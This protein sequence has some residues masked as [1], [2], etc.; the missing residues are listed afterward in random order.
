MQF[1]EHKCILRFN[2]FQLRS[3]VMFAHALEK[4]HL[5]Y[6][7]P[8]FDDFDT[9][10][11][12]QRN[13]QN[14]QDQNLLWQKA[15]NLRVQIKYT[16]TTRSYLPDPKVPTKIHV[17]CA[18]EL[19]VHILCNYGTR[20]NSTCLCAILVSIKHGQLHPHIFVQLWYTR[21][22]RARVVSLIRQFLPLLFN[23]VLAEYIQYLIAT[24]HP[25]PQT[26]Q[27]VLL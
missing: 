4:F 9:K 6:Q 25:C 19:D 17:Y 14:S 3:N 27:V 1:Y 26:E 13:I 18:H 22:E 8:L 20:T 21:A 15:T 10:M 23:Q 24:S 2:A 11:Y 12:E 5:V 16:K 7:Q